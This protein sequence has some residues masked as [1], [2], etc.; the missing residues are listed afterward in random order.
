MQVRQIPYARGGGGALEVGGGS[1]FVLTAFICCQRP[2]K[3]LCNRQYLPPQ[4]LRSP[5][6]AF[7]VALS[8]PPPPA[9]LPLKR[10]PGG[11]GAEGAACLCPYC[12]FPS[13][14]ARMPFAVHSP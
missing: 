11:G 6:T 12:G 9:S 1:P 5:V 2:P 14:R 10:I 7:A 8:P 13:K 4:P 3:P